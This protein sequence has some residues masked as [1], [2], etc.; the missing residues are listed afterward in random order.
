MDNPIRVLHVFASLDRGG[1][2]AMIMN[3]Y[4]NIDRS[5]VQFDFVVNKSDYTY[6]H[7]KEIR[8]LGGKVFYLPRYTITNHIKYKKS[9]QTLLREHPEWKIVHGHHTTPAF[10][11]LKIAKQFNR[12][13]IAH[14]HTAGFD[15]TIK[16][17][18]KVLMRVQV[19]NIADYL[20]ACSKKAALWMYGNKHHY[21]KVIKNSID[22]KLF[23]YNKDNRYKKRKELKL[24]NKFVIGH[25]GRF[26]KQ[27]NHDFIIE[28]FK[29]ILKRNSNA[30]LLLIGNGE[31]MDKI[32]NKI[33]DLGI[34]EN[35]II[36]GSRSDVPE[37]LHAMDVFLM[38]SIYE[39]LPVTVIEAQA[40]GLKC[41]ISDNITQEVKITN[42]VEFISLNQS[43]EYWV[44]EVMK[45]DNGYERENMYKKI[46]ESGYDVKD[47]AK[48]LEEFYLSEG[49]YDREKNKGKF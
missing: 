37:L 9:W 20:F 1:A 27:K 46:C 11:Y 26:Q 18:M 13:T 28:I 10:I 16:S 42:N 32:K 21:A 15:R 33:S 36:I 12:T 7:E 34:K 14:S 17:K 4:R 35:V 48:K 5:K 40:S 45:Y 47:N 25:I 49:L 31:L 24:N 41:I 2:E 8:L 3:L 43:P 22:A 38:P 39:G 6:A 44:K 19:K 29:E 30:L 23:I